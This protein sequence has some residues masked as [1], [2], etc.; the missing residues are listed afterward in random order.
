M[1]EYIFF[2]K[3]R[4]IMPWLCNMNTISKYREEQFIST[5]FKFTNKVFRCLLITFVC[6]V[7]VFPR[8]SCVE[9]LARSS[10]RAKLRARAE[11][12][13]SGQRRCSGA[14]RAPSDHRLRVS[15]VDLQRAVRRTGATL[16]A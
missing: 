14:R 6:F 16:C 2:N 10:A 7:N 3:Q 11:K 4:R 12:L 9:T 5:S 1:K 13:G 15:A 8:F